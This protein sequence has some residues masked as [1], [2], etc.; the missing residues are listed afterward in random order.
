VHHDRGTYRDQVGT[1]HYDTTAFGMDDR[2]MAHLQVAIASKLRRRECFY[3]SWIIPADQ[4]GGR[5][6]LWIDNGVPLRFVY[7]D[8]RPQR[9]NREW[10]ETL[11][12]S[13]N[14]TTGLI[15]VEEPQPAT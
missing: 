4:G 3:L 13:A 5:N 12:L 10:L 15:I 1:L 9:I 11:V 14:T 2:L 7:D 8:A 6:V